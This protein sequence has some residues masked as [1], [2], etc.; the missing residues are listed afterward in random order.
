MT[1]N[2]TTRRRFLQLAAG[3]GVATRAV[4]A[5]AGSADATVE[6]AVAT[7]TADDLLRLEFDRAMR[8]RAF[9]LGGTGPESRI[10]LTNWSAAEL[11][12]GLGGEELRD[13]TLERVERAPVQGTHG[14]GTRLV[15]AG[16]SAM[17]LEKTL[18]IVM[19][20]RY[21]GMAAYR[22][23][24]RNL[25]RH[26]L[27]LSGWRSHALLLL[28]P[29][30]SPAAPAQGEEPLFWSYCG[31][32]HSDRR[33][34]VQPVGAGFG[35]ENFMGMTASDY[36]GGT[37]IVDVWRRDCGIAVGHLEGVPRLLSLPVKRTPEGVQLAIT[38]SLARTL[39]PGERFET[40][41]TFLAT[42]SGDHFATL[43]AYR[44]LMAE[45]GLRPA[46]TPDS[47]YEPIWCAW[48]YERECTA[49][50]IEGTLPKVS[51]LGLR[52]AVI[53]DGW[54]SNVG[55]WQP[56]PRK[57]P[58]GAG[59]LLQLVRDIRTQRLE[60]RLWFAPLAVAPGSDVLHDHTD[61]LLLD[62]DGAPQNISWWNC[63]YLCPAYAGTVSYTG[64]L[65]RRFIGEWGFAGLKIDGQHLNAVAPCYNPAHRHARPEESVEKL[66]DFLHAL[67][68]TALREDPQAV[69]ELCPCGTAYS[70]FNFASMNQAPASDPESSWQVRH[71]GKTLKAL[72]GPGAAFAGDHVELSDGGDDF[73]STVGIGAIVSTKFTWPRDPKPKDSFLLTAAKEALWRRWIALYNER[74]L[75]RGS[76][77][78]E[79]YDIGFDKPETHVVERSGRLHYAF[80]ARSWS[81]PVALRGL[82]AGRYRLRDYFNDR[83]LGEVT[84]PG[85]SVRLAFE[86]FLLLEAL[87]V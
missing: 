19:W 43:D 17:G 52:W 74:L 54:Q 42:H 83:E 29:T 25:S 59:D 62:E 16:R 7:A 45:R 12:L 78:G 3:A 80:Y 53:D 60:P 49:Q 65:V 48:G 41:E 23:S 67:Y 40:P 64:T 87:P 11:L 26:R 18:R 34:W 30:G 13:F 73:A 61:M 15:L 51:E 27:A 36:G 9:H 46:P 79:L 8:S 4:L 56:H 70:F 81:G 24:Y 35:Q 68:T 20:S 10:A 50:L 14:Q 72:M 28:S 58:N 77:R 63:F 38:G 31:S 22:V 55:D 84:A 44:R 86:R 71:K 66:Q 2:A 1:D 76:Y 6:S 47:A 33:D 37:P 32:T 69:M 57:F 85:A 82:A 75:P 21:P 39:E 5:N